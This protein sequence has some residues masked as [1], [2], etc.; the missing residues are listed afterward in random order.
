MKLRKSHSK[1]SRL[2]AGIC[3]TEE[4]KKSLSYLLIVFPFPIY[5]NEKRNEG[6][7]FLTECFV[8]TVDFTGRA[9]ICGSWGENEQKMSLINQKQNDQ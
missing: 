1:I 2:P 3:M 4:K 9:D 7:L 8:N 5:C 6:R